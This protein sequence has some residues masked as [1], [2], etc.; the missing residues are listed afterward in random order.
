MCRDGTGAAFEATSL[1]K[2]IYKGTNQ[3][4]PRTHSNPIYRPM[5]LKRAEPYKVLNQK[6][7]R[8]R[9]SSSSP[10]NRGEPVF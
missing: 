5:Q 4:F 2:L 8:I 7:E 10:S 6:A 1:V 9:H 3:R